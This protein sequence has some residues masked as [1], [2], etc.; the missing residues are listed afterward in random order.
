MVCCGQGEEGGDPASLARW[1]DDSRAVLL[2][3]D[4]RPSSSSS[5]SSSLAGRVRAALREAGSAPELEEGWTDLRA[6]IEGALGELEE[7]AAE[8][9]QLSAARE[10]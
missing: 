3:G 5:S 9:L 4:E 10:A 6:E 8:L 2:S 1:L 7:A